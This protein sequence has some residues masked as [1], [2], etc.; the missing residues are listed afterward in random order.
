MEIL[1]IIAI[2]L[3]QI[4]V[5]ELLITVP[6]ENERW[7]YITSKDSHKSWIAPLPKIQICNTIVKEEEEQKRKGTRES[8]EIFGQN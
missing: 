8:P 2:V 3:S 4:E 5:S 1:L 6:F 7:R